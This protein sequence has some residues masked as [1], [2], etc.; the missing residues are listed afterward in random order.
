M[1]TDPEGEVMRR[2]ASKR[3]FPINWVSRLWV[4]SANQNSLSQRGGVN[5]SRFRLS[6]L[7]SLALLFGT[8]PIL[9]SSFAVGTCK[10]S[11]PSYPKISAAVAAVPAGSTVLVCPGTYAE[12]V[13]IAQPLTLQGI[14]SGNSGQAVI[15]VPSGGLATT[16]SIFLGTIA[17]QVEV[18]TGPVNI[19]NITVDAAGGSNNCSASLVGIYYGSGS[20]GTVN[21]VTVRNELNG[22]C[23]YGIAAENGTATNESVVIENS[24]VH[25]VD[26]IGIIAGSDQTPPTLT[27][28]I[29]ANDVAASDIG[30]YAYTGAAG[31]VTGNIVTA[32]SYGILSIT[33][34]VL[35]SG[36]TIT[37]SPTGIYAGAPGVS[38]KSNK[39]WNSSIAGIVLFGTGMTI[40][41]NVI[42]KSPVGI[43][44]NC[45]T[46]NTVTQNT[47]ND[48]AIGLDLVPLITATP[49]DSFLNVATIRTDGCGFVAAHAT[50]PPSP[51]NH[52]SD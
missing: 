52:H 22:G 48:A 8:R 13:I 27:A 11:L 42:T 43:E 17:A 30:I 40:Q 19:I 36:N 9:A 39:I 35:I 31:S 44:F 51:I 29:K 15:T 21:Q 49:A 4:L 46:G 2:I 14:S 37:N 25:D 41:S 26:F 5:M 24:S 34:S 38:A 28:T 50:P 47:I 33:P 1:R 12:Q 16:P 45:Q 10:P 32:G 7:L 18:T 6:F 3:K 23:G 20:S